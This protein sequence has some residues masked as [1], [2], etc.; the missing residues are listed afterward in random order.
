MYCFGQKSINPYNSQE[1]MLRQV[2][3]DI[4]ATKAL[5]SMNEREEKVATKDQ[6]VTFA[7]FFQI[8]ELG[9]LTLWLNEKNVFEINHDD[10]ASYASKMAGEVIHC[11]KTSKTNITYV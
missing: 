1:L 9:L 2:T 5:L 11:L 3:E 10:I 4:K 7:D 6:V 8:Y